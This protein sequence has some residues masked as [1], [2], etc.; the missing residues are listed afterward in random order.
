M[1]TDQ[2]LSDNG[3]VRHTAT[4]SNLDFIFFKSWSAKIGRQEKETASFLFMTWTEWR[5]RGNI[6]IT[7]V[8]FHDELDQPVTNPP[9]SDVHSPGV[10]EISYHAGSAPLPVA[11]TEPAARTKSMRMTYPF[12]KGELTE[13]R[14][15]VTFIGTG[16]VILGAL[17]I[18]GLLTGFWKPEGDDELDRDAP[19]EQSP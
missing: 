16:I 6:D 7:S 11:D 18:F 8:E 15:W 4:A 1:A 10:H 17:L 19:T 3:N 14:N 12:G 13:G 2:V 5:H 9:P